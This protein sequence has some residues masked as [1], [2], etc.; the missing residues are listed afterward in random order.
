MGDARD[1]VLGG[2]LIGGLAVSNQALPALDR[3]PV[4]PTIV[5]LGLTSLV[6]LHAWLSRNLI[7]G[8]PHA[9]LLLLFVAFLPGIFESGGTSYSASKLPAMVIGFVGAFCAIELLRGDRARRA[10]VGCL[11]VI[12]IG[13]AVTLFVAGTVDPL[14]GRATI[15]GASPLGVGFMCALATLILGLAAFQVKAPVKRAALVI[16]ALGCAFQSSTTGSRGPLLAALLALAL[17]FAFGRGRSRF[18]GL[19]LVAVAGYASYSLVV[20][21]RGTATAR[22]GELQSEERITLWQ[23]CLEAIPERPWAG[24]GW[25]D[26]V[27]TVALPQSFYVAAGARQYAHNIFIEAAL[28]GGFVALIGLVCILV[29]AVARL[30]AASGFSTTDLALF[31]ISLFAIANAMVSSDLG[32]TRLLWVLIGVGLA[33]VLPSGV[34]PVATSTRDPAQPRSSKV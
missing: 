5:F 20:G 23:R 22:L 14:S 29:I 1:A 4:D 31:A 15:A 8:R 24:T 6:A 26:M 2:I 19:A 3:L 27:E 21:A 11:A 7:V 18:R 9:L 12:G 32:G 16:L 13:V 10:F 33:T 28:E 17:V 34:P 30:R 25:G